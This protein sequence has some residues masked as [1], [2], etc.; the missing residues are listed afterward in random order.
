MAKRSKRGSEMRKMFFALERLGSLDLSQ[1]AKVM[2]PQTQPYSRARSRVEG[3]MLVMEEHGYRL[4]E[5]D[6][7]RISICR[8]MV[9]VDW[10]V[11]GGQTYRQGRV[12]GLRARR[13]S[14]KVSLI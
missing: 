4:A 12:V 14:L 2:Y 5:D 13:R 8:E 9:D 3:L 11:L 1:L 10:T 6:A 7:G